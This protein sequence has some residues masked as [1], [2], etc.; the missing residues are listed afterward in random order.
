MTPMVVGTT[1]IERGVQAVCEEACRWSETM[2]A[3]GT[4]SIEVFGGGREGASSEK[5]NQ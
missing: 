3:V 1:S 4:T 5:R 2:E